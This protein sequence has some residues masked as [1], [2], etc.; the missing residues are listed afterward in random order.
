MPCQETSCAIHKKRES[1]DKNERSGKM[2]AKN[3]ETRG[4]G[5]V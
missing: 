2:T 5:N 1:A 4:G 3:L